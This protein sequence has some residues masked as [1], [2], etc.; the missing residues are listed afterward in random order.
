VDLSYIGTSEMI[1]AEASLNTAVE[2]YDKI[3]TNP[4][5]RE[6]NLKLTSEQISVEN[7]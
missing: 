1:K 2:I 3:L 6:M 4:I 7:I 5:F